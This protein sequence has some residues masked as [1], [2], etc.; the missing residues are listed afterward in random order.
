M[1]N[2]GHADLQRCTACVLVNGV[3]TGYAGY[4]LTDKESWGCSI[5]GMDEGL[6]S[7]GYEVATA[8]LPHQPVTVTWRLCLTSES[9]HKMH[10]PLCS[11]IFFSMRSCR[12]CTVILHLLAGHRGLGCISHTRGGPSGHGRS[13]ST[14]RSASACHTWPTVITPHILR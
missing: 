8:S 1:A 11:M 13:S 5:A 12:T 2:L 7:C 14:I 4:V 3:S 9:V 10:S 6:N